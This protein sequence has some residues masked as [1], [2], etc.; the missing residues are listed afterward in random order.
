MTAAFRTLIGLVLGLAAGITIA[1]FNTPSLRAFSS[2]MEVAGAVFIN[3]IRMTVIPL[4]VS[5]IITGVA[6]ASDDRTVRRVG[7]AGVLLFVTAVALASSLSMMIGLPAMERLPVDHETAESLRQSADVAREG[8]AATAGGLPSVSQWFADL[9]PANPFK[10]A[11]DGAML[12]LIVFSLALGVGLTRVDPSRR[13]V[14]L[15]FLQAVAEALLAVVRWIL[16]AAPAGVFALAVPVAARM[17]LTAAGALMY[18]VLIVGIGCV[19]FAALV[20]YPAAVFLGRLSWRQFARAVASAQAI[21]FSSRSSLASLP[22]MMEAARSRLNLREEVTGFLLPLAAAMFRAGTAVGFTMGVLFLA[23]LYGVTLGPAALVSIVLTVVVTSFGSPGIPSGSVLVI[24][25]VLMAGGIP[26]E[27][28]GILLGI[29][30]LPDMFRT[31]TNVT[32]DMAAAVIIDRRLF[33]RQAGMHL[34]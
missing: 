21:A 15:Q 34:P 13:Q 7:G 22:V 8:V 18:Y 31:T 27:G 25:P 5:K 20:I 10:A 2:V 33:G 9:I 23:R 32:A 16:A 1:A 24:V 12:P 26:V 17:G 28:V 11:V 14:V 6:S 30:T 3:A 4:I 29:D 19:A